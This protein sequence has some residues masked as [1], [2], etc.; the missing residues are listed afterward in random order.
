MA[1]LNVNVEFLIQ[2]RRENS[3]AAQAYKRAGPGSE[4]MV[5]NF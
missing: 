4:I 3:R 1:S 5:L 2:S